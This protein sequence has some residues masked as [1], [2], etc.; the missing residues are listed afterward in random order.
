M[1]FGVAGPAFGYLTE[2]GGDSWT[3]VYEDDR[4]AVF[5]NSLK[6]SK[7]THGIALN[8]SST[9]A[10]TLAGQSQGKQA[11]LQRE[12]KAESPGLN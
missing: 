1:V 5:F 10:I 4:E 2:D 11:S 7:S 12:A 3:V 6:F 9:K 8:P